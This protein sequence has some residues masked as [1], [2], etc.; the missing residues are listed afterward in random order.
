MSDVEARI[1]EVR[2][3]QQVVAGNMQVGCDIDSVT[4]PGDTKKDIIV[5]LSITNTHNNRLFFADIN[6]GSGGRLSCMKADEQM[7]IPNESGEQETDP[8]QEEFL[9]EGG[10]DEGDDEDADNYP[11]PQ[12]PPQ[13][14]REYINYEK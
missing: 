3:D 14:E 10:D 13:P 6:M 7:E 11:D 9:E 8:G 5:K 2:W 1:E 12:P 4:T